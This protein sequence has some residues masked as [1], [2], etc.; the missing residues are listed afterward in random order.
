MSDNT[1]VIDLASRYAAAFGIMAVNRRLN[2]AT[3]EGEKGNYAFELYPSL[4]NDVERI[5]LSHGTNSLTFS[6]MLT[7]VQGIFA[8]PLIV[9]FQREKNL[10][11]TEVNGSD[12][13]VVERW[14]T[15]PWKINIEGILVDV[16]NRVYPQEHIHQLEEFFDINDIVNVEGVQFED[17]RIDSLYFKSIDISPIAGFQDT[18]K[19]RLEASSIQPIEFNVLKP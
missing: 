14:G 1:L 10:V 2:A 6:A 9:D 4:D 19:F 7:P 15:K 5:V 16:E 11:E 13:V 17:K 18:I 8:P 12:N 3:V